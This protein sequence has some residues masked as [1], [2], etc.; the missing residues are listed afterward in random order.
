MII[1]NLMKFIIL[2]AFALIASQ[3]VDTLT[4]SVGAV[5]TANCGKFTATYTLPGATSP[6][7]IAA[8]VTNNNTATTPTWTHMCYKV[9]IVTSAITA[10]VNSD[11]G[12][13][14]S[15]ADLDAISYTS[16]TTVTALSTVAGTWTATD[17]VASADFKLSAVYG[18]KY[19]Q[20]AATFTGAIS[21]ATWST[22]LESTCA[23]DSSLASSDA[24]SFVLSTFAALSFF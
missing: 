18:V 21:A 7:Y 3:A 4:L 17:G 13:C 6:M 20:P 11:T 2:L 24:F 15:T 14:I 1:T 5:G 8:A 23:V 9:T 22:V 10:V 12:T 16:G 19:T